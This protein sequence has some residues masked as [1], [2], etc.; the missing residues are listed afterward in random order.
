[1]GV[2]VTESRRKDAPSSG[3]YWH[4]GVNNRS[5][6]AVGFCSP[7]DDHSVGI[8]IELLDASHKVIRLPDPSGGTFDAAGDFDR[9]F[10]W[11]SSPV[12]GRVSTEGTTEMAPSEMRSLIEE[13]D[14]L[15]PASNDGPERRGLLRLK[16]LAEVCSDR[17]GTRL[18]FY[19]D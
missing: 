2:R 6:G 8:W 7:C 18:M 13:V 16:A 19:G 9:F 10:V 11:G 1:M 17:P 12:L 4:S 5:V 14:G 3:R 15:V